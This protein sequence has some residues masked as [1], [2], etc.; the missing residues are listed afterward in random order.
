MSIYGKQVGARHGATDKSLSQIRF[1]LDER[2]A[3]N[4]KC[5]SPYRVVLAVIGVYMLSNLVAAWMDTQSKAII[6]Y[7]QHHRNAPIS[8]YLVEG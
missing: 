3:N 7:E 2:K 1:A 6:S 5:E 4:P 8:T